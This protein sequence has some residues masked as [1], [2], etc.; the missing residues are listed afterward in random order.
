M[1]T[2]P[3]A[4]LLG[5][6]MLSFPS[7]QAE[8]ACERLGVSPPANPQSK[9]TSNYLPS[10]ENKLAHAQYAP[11][12][13][14]ER[15]PRPTQCTCVRR[16][17]PSPP[18]TPRHSRHSP[19]LSR[20]DISLLLPDVV[21][22]LRDTWDAATS[23]KARAANMAAAVVVSGKVGNGR[24]KHSCFSSGWG[25]FCCL[26]PGRRGMRGPFCVRNSLWRMQEKMT[27]WCQLF[28]RECR[29]SP[30]IKRPGSCSK[31]S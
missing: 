24:G 4:G 23:S 26:E 18:V 8:G 31:A 14:P 2:K 29:L 3:R 16:L 21:V 28:S 12:T 13:P 17:L 5:P 25:C 6:N 7:Y 10:K 1:A 9:N 19:P 20:P 15:P 27:R 11:A 22:S 30:G